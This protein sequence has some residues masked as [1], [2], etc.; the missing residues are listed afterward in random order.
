MSLTDAE[1]EELDALLASYGV[2]PVPHYTG[3]L[4]QMIRETD[5]RFQFYRHVEVLI[6]Y[7]EALVAGE[8]KR[9]MVFEPPRHG[10]SELVSRKLPAYALAKNPEEWVGLVSYEA[11]MAEG[12]SRAARDHYTRI[13]GEMRDD[14]SAVNLWQTPYGG[15]MWAAGMGGPITGRGAHLA[16]ID[17]PIKN[18]E[19]A[20]SETIRAKHRDWYD[21]TFYTRLEPNA[22]LLVT[23]TRWHEADLAGHILS[24]EKDDPE[25]WTIVNLPALAEGMQRVFPVSCTVVKDWRAEGEALCPE[26][27]DAETLGKIKRRVGSYFWS[28]LYQQRPTPDE[29]GMFK[30]QWWRYYDEPPK[31]VD[32][33]ILSWD[34]AFKDTDGSDYVVGQVWGVKGPDLYLLDQVRD[35]MDFPTTEKAVE[36]LRR[37]WPHAL[38]TYIE[39]KANGPAII[40]SLRRNRQIG[41]VVPVE[42]KGSKQARGAAVA[43]LVEAG[44]VWLPAPHMAPWVRELVDE[45]A[46]FPLGEHDDQVDAMSQALAQL[47]PS[48]IRPPAPKST[49]RNPEKSGPLAETIRGRAEPAKLPGWRPQ[50]A[51]TKTGRPVTPTFRPGVTKR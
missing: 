44:N 22:R 20:A 17:D 39:D 32:R 49:Y 1:R 3:T 18:A 47:A 33:M 21:S 15:G 29:G 31:E 8:V 5:H 6:E 2:V 9:L 38:A 19:E 16:T 35:R 37:K 30:R 13:G 12:F 46:S 7:L 28:A 41:G 14:S 42:P 40:A 4:R 51:T 50:P 25:G 10:K 34:M 45:C 36:S 23:L 26:R 27:Y 43:P 48:A 24:R 11:T